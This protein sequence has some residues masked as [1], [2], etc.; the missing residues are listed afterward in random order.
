MLRHVVEK[1][2]ININFVQWNLFSSNLTDYTL[3]SI[4]CWWQGGWFAVSKSSIIMGMVC[5]VQDVL[6]CLVV[7]LF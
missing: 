7:T 5:S 2:D 4:Y 1:N 6:G 3:L